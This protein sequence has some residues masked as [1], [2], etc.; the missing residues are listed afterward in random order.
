M[1]SRLSPRQPLLG[2]TKAS[3]VFALTESLQSFGKEAVSPVS[4]ARFVHRDR[5]GDPA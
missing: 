5:Q 1:T 4:D 2:V 3:G